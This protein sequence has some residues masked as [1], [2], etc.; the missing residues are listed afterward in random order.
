MP[1]RSPGCRRSFSTKPAASCDVDSLN[2]ANVCDLPSNQTASSDGCRRARQR[3]ISAIVRIA[4]ALPKRLRYS[5]QSFH[6]FFKRN[7]RALVLDLGYKT[8]AVF[9]LDGK[10]EA[11]LLSA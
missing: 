7:R 9:D 2:S 10:S 5:A 3:S 1:T 4:C 8:R 6:D 11:V